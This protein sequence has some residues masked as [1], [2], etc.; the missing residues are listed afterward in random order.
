MC[1]KSRQHRALIA[2]LLL[3]LSFSHLAHAATEVEVSPVTQALPGFYYNPTGIV[4]GSYLYVYAQTY[5]FECR[6]GLGKPP[7]DP[8]GDVIHAFRATL[9]PDGTPGS[10]VKIGRISPCAV[11][12]PNPS[13]LASFG[14][15]QI[16][17][18]TWKGVLSYHLLADMS[19]FSNFHEIW[20]GWTTNGLDWTWEVT[21]QSNCP[22][23]TT[24]PDPVT[25]GGTP[26]RTITWKGMSQ[27]IISIDPNLGRLIVNP[28]LLATQPGTNNAE[29]WGYLK[30]WDG[31]FNTTGMRI[32]FDAV[33]TPRLHLLASTTPPFTYTA[34]IPNNRIASTSQLLYLIPNFNAKSLLFD[35]QSGVYQLWGGSVV[36]GLYKQWV[37]CAPGSTTG[38]EITCGADTKNFGCP[39]GSCLIFGQCQPYGTKAIAFDSNNYQQQQVG[40]SFYWYSATRFSLGPQESVGSH[41]RFM[42]S[43]YVGARDFPFRWNAPNGKRYLFSATSDNAICSKFHAPPYVVKSEVVRE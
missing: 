25:P 43:G 1:W 38:S 3:M 36:H 11:Y 18:A 41:S 21:G 5:D 32:T 16:F 27:P 15:G 24:C 19:D 10:F 39:A 34:P 31:Q 9:Q 40:S 42:P 4:I 29:W 22:A 8:G 26:S 17:K 23:G 35:A 28:V 37:N 14:P 33:G 30:F 12:P 7:G 6:N 13:V 20:H 2:A